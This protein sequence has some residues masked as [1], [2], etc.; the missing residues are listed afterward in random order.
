MYATICRQAHFVIFE[1]D[2]H[3]AVDSG[4][5]VDDLCSV[6]LKNLKLQFG[7]NVDV[8][9]EFRWEW[10]AIP[11]IYHTPFYCYAYAFGNLLSLALY[12]RYR[13]EGS[14]FVPKYL[15]L[16]SHGGSMSPR[17][18][19]D[20]VGVDVESAS[21]WDGGFDVIREMVSELRKL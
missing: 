11:H 9:E 5:R 14:Q 6:Y 2:A 16:L 10:V 1:I 18:M 13:T 17:G 15:R 7:S 8:P 12:R 3:E 20:E 21:F 4:A 19:L